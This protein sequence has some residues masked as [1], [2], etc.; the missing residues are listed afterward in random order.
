MRKTLS[1]ILTLLC[2]L[3]VVFQFSLEGKLTSKLTEL[4]ILQE[5]KYGICFTGT[6]S[7]T[8]LRTLGFNEVYK[9]TIENETYIYGVTPFSHSFIRESFG[10][11]N[12][13]ILIKQNGEI[14]VGFPL[15][16][17]SSTIS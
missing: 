15:I 10:R 13:Q 8:L 5:T 16:Y 9:T 17:T 11:Y 2:L 3:L 4:D 7:D 6:K 14:R 12:C 1:I